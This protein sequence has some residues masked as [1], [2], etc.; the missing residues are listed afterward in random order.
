MKVLLP[1]SIPAKGLFPSVATV[2]DDD[3]CSIVIVIVTAD[4]DGRCRCQQLQYPLFPLLQQATV[5]RDGQRASFKA[6][7]ACS[8]QGTEIPR[9]Q[10][11]IEQQPPPIIAPREGLCAACDIASCLR[12]TK[13]EPNWL[14]LPGC[15]ARSFE[16]LF[17]LLTPRGG[18]QI[19]N[20][21]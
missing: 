8:S 11:F 4:Q 3:G 16:L 18:A 20:C 21:R 14:L 1:V 2:D 9:R 12:A 7:C 15:F 17:S 10:P 19:L 13:L 5:G 6:C